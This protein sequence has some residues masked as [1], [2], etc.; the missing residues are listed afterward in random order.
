VSFGGD[1]ACQ[2][3]GAGAD[4]QRIF[5]YKVGHG[6]IY[7]SRGESGSGAGNSC[8]NRACWECPS[9]YVSGYVSDAAFNA[10]QPCGPEAPSVISFDCLVNPDG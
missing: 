9:S 3:D 1:G 7:R 8:A 6:C 2:A 4:D 10:C 5:F